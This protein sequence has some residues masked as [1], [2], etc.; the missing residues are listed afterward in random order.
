[1]HVE[2]FPEVFRDAGSIP[3]A[4]S[5]PGKRT[6]ARDRLSIVGRSAPLQ[7]GQLEVSVFCY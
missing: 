4:S 6:R 7:R 5:F 1:M 2:A 3:A